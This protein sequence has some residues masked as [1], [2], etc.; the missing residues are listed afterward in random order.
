MSGYSE[1]VKQSVTNRSNVPNSSGVKQSIEVIE[2]QIPIH[3]NSNHHCKQ[4]ENMLSLSENTGVNISHSE[5]VTDSESN[6]NVTTGQPRSSTNV[7]DSDHFIPVINSNRTQNH[8]SIDFTS[9]KPVSQNSGLVAFYMGNLKKTLSKGVIEQY[10]VKRG[11]YLRSIQI[12]P[13]KKY[14]ANGAKIVIDPRYKDKLVA[15]PLP[16]GIYMRQWYDR[17]RRDVPRGTRIIYGSRKY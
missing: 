17:N 3:D 8:K 12:I 2:Y 11:I 5:N 14:E 13:C 4:A 10:M 7:P 1:V 16:S 15:I 6:V 9:Q